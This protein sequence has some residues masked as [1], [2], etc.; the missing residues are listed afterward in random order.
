MN[1]YL[2]HFNP[3]HD[4]KNGQFTSGGSSGHI[5]AV[6]SK[7]LKANKNDKIFLDHL[8][9][10]G[11]IKDTEEAR[12]GISSGSVKLKKGSDLY[13]RDKILGHGR[14]LK[15]DVDNHYY[16]TTINNGKNTTY[17]MISRN[18]NRAS[19]SAYAREG[20]IKQNLSDKTVKYIES[21]FK[22]EE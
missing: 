14:I 8:K 15:E 5:P 17:A 2:M 20:Y 16:I 18:G 12:K 9:K 10:E 4:P 6:A 11:I 22:D 1:N 21:L 19:I 7:Q 3:F 13:V